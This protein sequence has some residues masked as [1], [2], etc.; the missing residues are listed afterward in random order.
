MRRR[1][2]LVRRRYAMVEHH[3]HSSRIAHFQD[4]HADV[5]LKIVVDENYRLDF[6]GHHITGSHFLE[7]GITRE[8]F[9]RNGHSHTAISLRICCRG[10]DVA[11]SHISSVTVA[12]IDEQSDISAQNGALSRQNIPHNNT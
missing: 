6:Y 4:V 1:A 3:D 10:S 8:N 5:L 7:A 9:F 11:G 12:G 2:L